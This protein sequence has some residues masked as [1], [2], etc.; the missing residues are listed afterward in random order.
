MRNPF[1]VGSWVRGEAFHGRRELLQEVL[2][3]D[4]K[5]FWAVGTRRI[6]KTSFLKELEY[7]SQRGE[8]PAK[9]MPLFWDLEG[10]KDLD[11]FKDSLLEGVE[12]AEE[13]LA[14]IGVEVEEL[15]SLD[16]FGI[17][18]CL[19][20]A[21]RKA[22]LKLFL[23]CDEC[24]E[25]LNLEKNNPD[26]LPRLRRVFQEG[27]SI[28][29]VLTATKRLSL[30]ERNTA[31]QTSP[32]LHGFVPPL[33]LTRLRD[34]EATE[35]IRSGNFD[36]DV[37]QEIKDKTDRHPFLVQ[38]VC[39]RLF[40]TGDLKKI[41]EEI[42]A[43]E[44]VS[45]FFSVDYEYLSAQEKEVILHVARRRKTSSLDLETRG[46]MSSSQMEALLYGLR[47]MGYIRQEAD[48]CFIA[49][50]FFEKWLQREHGPEATTAASRSG[51]AAIPHFD[52][53]SS[54]ELLR[55][56]QGGDR[57]ALLC[58]CSRY[59]SA[60]RRWADGRVPHSMRERLDTDDLLQ[61]VLF[62][63]FSQ[64]EPQREG[65]LWEYLRQELLN[66]I[67]QELR[68][69][70]PQPV[71][72]GDS[73]VDSSACP[74][75]EIVGREAL[76]R[77]EAALA[78]LQ[79]EERQAIV[80]RIEMGCTYEQ[81]ATSLERPSPGAARMAVCRALVRLASEMF[82]GAGPRRD[83]PR[84]LKLARSIA[85]GAHVDWTE[86]Q[87]A[88]EESD[89]LGFLDALRDVARLAW[90]HRSQQLA[91]GVD[92]SRA[93]LEGGP[94]SP[95]EHEE[96]VP[97]EW[98]EGLPF[99]RWGH[100]EIREKIGEGVFGEVYRAWE[101]TLEREVALKL[102]RSELGSRVPGV[103][104]PHVLQEGRNLARIRHPNVVTVYGAEQLAG[105][106]GIWMEFI[107]GRTLTDV[108]EEHGAFGAR[109]AASIGV[110]L[111]R[112]L[113]AVHRAGLV[114]RDIKT[115]NVMRETGGR[116]VLMDFGAGTDAR[117]HSQARTPAGTPVYLAPEIFRGERA[118]VRSDLYSLGV[119]LYYLVS[120]SFPV[121]G[122]TLREI[123]R[124][125]E[126]GEGQLLREVRPDLSEAFVQVIERAL[127]P[128]PDER[129]ASSG[130]MEHALVSAL[131]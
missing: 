43:D 83:D 41:I 12:A 100:L 63:A 30:L 130:Q 125:H 53:Q 78:K 68:S 8:Y 122:H 102:L 129:F 47:Q 57:E 113:T 3:G 80:T 33:Y 87:A 34:D 92:T 49:N 32:F 99:Q 24:E 5:F 60:F 93:S 17:L 98:A 115:R 61:Q 105:R 13:R 29:T 119:L 95:A 69:T 118:T 55:R 127:R 38:L 71:P 120:A 116:I 94:A 22:D 28:H 66:R 21:A 121:D 50:W 39:K 110:D 85:D 20:R 4:R 7:L 2:Q 44:M 11:G 46:R 112:A 37:V 86:A 52:G 42:S 31:P 89:E 19:K 27:E 25:L 131:V 9:Y 126:R 128:K 72:A 91:S 96:G 84:F 109:E 56:A 67:R 1:I 10:S 107:H 111:C 103:T 123:A 6:S 73:N 70:P 101:T 77:Y 48:S 88:S 90:F 79:P 16:T 15:E 36:P 64:I 106:V 81:V 54:L 124:M 40:D 75:E 104:T 59:Q 65:E 18:R 26:A 76:Q 114:H 108:L 74:Q 82:A 23:L 51:A 62:G 14:E 97:V 45:R 58:L 35:L 117:F